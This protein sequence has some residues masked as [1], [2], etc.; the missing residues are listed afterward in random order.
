MINVEV[1]THVAALNNQVADMRAL[2]ITQC[3]LAFMSLV[4]AVWGPWWGAALL[5]TLNGVMVIP[6]ADYYR[7]WSH[8]L[9]QLME[10]TKN[11]RTPHLD[12]M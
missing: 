1:A 3:V 4:L 8:N 2:L 10:A 11:V 7:R 12:L 6:L 5:I 9:R